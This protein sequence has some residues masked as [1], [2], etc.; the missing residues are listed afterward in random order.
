[1]DTEQGT[2][3]RDALGHGARIGLAGLAGATAVV[4]A[5]GEALAPE[6]AQA[7]ATTSTSGLASGPAVPPIPVP[8]RVRRLLGVELL[9]LF[10]Y[11]RVLSSSLLAPHASRALAPLQAQEE[12]HVRALRT[13]LR[14]LGAA[15]PAAP[16]TV[17]QADRDLAHRKVAQRL[18]QLKGAKDALR[19]L[20]AV[21]RV[22]V[23]AYF[24]S[25]ITLEDRSLITLV[26]EM[27]G[28]DAQHEV[29]IGEL[30]YDGDATKAVPSGLVQGAQ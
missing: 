22:A 13:R 27:M 14:E 2:T 30:L 11:Q 7:A 10:A 23:G 17:A 1:M 5:G 18:G 4:L 12:Q 20:L 26:T 19:L 29:V 15:A 24:V 16:Q 28:C 25:L 3:R 9:V 6:R 8:E 21:E